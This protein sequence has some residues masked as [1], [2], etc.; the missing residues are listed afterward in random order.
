M[1]AFSFQ[2][3]GTYY[4]FYQENRPLCRRH[5]TIA[6]EIGHCVLNHLQPGASAG[7]EA[8]TEAVRDLDLSLFCF[9]LVVSCVWLPCA[10]E[11]VLKKPQMLR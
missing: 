11:I 6:H 5:Y 2:F 10:V 1:D 3:E 8:A 9:T 7:A 4:I